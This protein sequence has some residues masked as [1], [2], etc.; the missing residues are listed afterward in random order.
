MIIQTVAY[1][2][3]GRS[4]IAP[5]IT[6]ARVQAAKR[7]GGRC[8]LTGVGGR[9][10]GHHLFDVSTFPFFATMARN[11]IMID[12]DLHKE[13]HSWL[14]GTKA[15]C[16]PIHFYYWWWIVKRP[17]R[18]LLLFVLFFLATMEFYQWL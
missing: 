4:A 2:L 12:T 15:W 1:W 11:I 5:A 3:F 13:F 7:A 10:D 16:T 6:A 17:V 9:L 8:E 18:T 14:G